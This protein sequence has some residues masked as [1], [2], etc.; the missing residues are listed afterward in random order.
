MHLT[1]SLGSIGIGTID[2]M[3]PEISVAQAGGRW[4]GGGRQSVVGLEMVVRR[5][6]DEYI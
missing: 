6:H 4:K 5:R 3:F 1:A 2:A